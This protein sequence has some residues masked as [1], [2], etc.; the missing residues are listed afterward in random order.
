MQDRA[1][2]IEREAARQEKEACAV[3]GNNFWKRIPRIAPL[4]GAL[5]T[6]GLTIDDLGVASFHG[7]STVAND[8]NESAVICQQLQAPWPQEGQRRYGYL[9]EVPH[10][11]PQGCRRCLDV[12][13]LSAGSQQLVWF[14]ATA[15]PTTSTRSWSSSTTLS[16][17]AAASRPMVSR[18]SP[19]PRS[20]SV[21]RVL[22]PLA[23]TPS[24]CSPLSTR[25]TYAAYSTK[26][27]ARQKK[28]Y[29]LLP[30]RHDQQHPLR[31]QEQGTIHGR[32][33]SAVFLNPDARVT[34]D[35]KT[36]ELTYSTTSPRRPR[37]RSRHPR[38]R[39]A[40]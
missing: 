29:R 4:R 13:R 15:T 2:H 24:T 6:W 38:R 16:T 35:K 33:A 36:S 25:P 30:Q 20:V 10:R 26:V 18:P 3:S 7:T 22:R 31:R 19:S 40:G 27:E 39:R 23:S 5:A 28:A 11:S 9:P 17:P 32:A 14:P 8:K 12:Q 34:V 21:R 37:T 1:Q